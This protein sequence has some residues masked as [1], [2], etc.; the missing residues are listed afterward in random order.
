M[1]GDDQPAE[2]VLVGSPQ[3]RRRLEPAPQEH[4][5][6]DDWLQSQ[7]HQSRENRGAENQR[8][9]GEPSSKDQI[10]SRDHQEPHERHQDGEEL[11][12]REGEVGQPPLG[13]L[14]PPEGEGVVETQDL[15][16]ATDRDDQ[17]LRPTRVLIH[18]I[19][20]ATP[21]RNAIAPEPTR[22]MPM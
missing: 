18:P 9:A 2:Q 17:R 16:A 12:V 13:V 4:H 7:V 8:P 11:A 15:G 5:P 20:D 3:Q 1:T 14:V 19:L 10:A 6:G 21:E 22:T